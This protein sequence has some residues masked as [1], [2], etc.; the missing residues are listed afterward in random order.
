[1]KATWSASK[2]WI[3]KRDFL[4][5]H[6]YTEK[7]VQHLKITTTGD[8][9]IEPKNEVSYNIYLAAQIQ[10]CEDL[11]LMEF[12]TLLFDSCFFQMRQNFGHGCSYFVKRSRALEEMD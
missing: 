4:Y 11:S 10:R 1:M 9:A 2:F 5:V 12:P 8:T 7:Q 3:L 6:V